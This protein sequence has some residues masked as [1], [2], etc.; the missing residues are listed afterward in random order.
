V[1]PSLKT[2]RLGPILWLLC[3]QYFVAE[4]TARFAWKI[5]Y[6]FKTNFISDLGAVRCTLSGP[7]PVCSPLHALMNASFVLQ[8]LLIFFGSILNRK[9]F[10]PGRLVTLAM[11]LIAASG[12]G[13]LLVG[14]APEDANPSLHYLGAAEHFLLDNLGMVL[15]GCLLLISRWRATP[16]LAS[17]T[18][19]SGVIGL[20][21]TSLLSM[22]IL[23][24]CG[25]GG[26]ERFAAYPFTLWLS[27]AGFSL[28]VHR[29]AFQ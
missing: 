20:T 9:L 4:Q 24:G 10:P 28:L 12:A 23:L 5:P 6:S 13:V 29:D 3:F 16:I 15:L 27:I 17:Y 21:A 22:K 8:G 2:S 25:V 1:P 18:L 26:M 7:D 14:L 11:A 19:A